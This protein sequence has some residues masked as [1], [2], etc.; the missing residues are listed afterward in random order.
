MLVVSFENGPSQVWD[1]APDNAGD[2]APRVREWP[3]PGRSSDINAW[4]WTPDGSRL[5]GINSGG[6]VLI[7]KA[8]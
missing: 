1:I 4:T 7:W 8:R 6:Q 5:A 2:A 3:W